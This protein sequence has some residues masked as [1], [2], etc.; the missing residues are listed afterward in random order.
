LKSRDPRRREDQQEEPSD[1][2]NEDFDEDDT[3]LTSHTTENTFSAH[4]TT[5]L[6]LFSDQHNVI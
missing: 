3:H 2:D 1:D 6:L 5:P 4:Q